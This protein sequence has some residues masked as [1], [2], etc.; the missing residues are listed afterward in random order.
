M[1]SEFNEAVNYVNSMKDSI[2]VTDEIK[3]QLY[4]LFKRITVGKCSQKGGKRPIFF[5]ILAVRK[6]DSWMR[7]D[8]RDENECIQEYISIVNSFR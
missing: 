2:E 3:E 6:Y 5:N 8:N 1:N 4:G 7:Y